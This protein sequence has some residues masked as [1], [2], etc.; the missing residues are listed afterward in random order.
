MIVNFVDSFCWR[1]AFVFSSTH[2]VKGYPRITEFAKNC[3]IM[4]NKHLTHTWG[5]VKGH[6]H[7]PAPVAFIEWKLGPSLAEIWPEIPRLGPWLKSEWGG[8]NWEGALV[9]FWIGP[10]FRIDHWNHFQFNYRFQIDF[11]T[12]FIKWHERQLMCKYR[13]QNLQTFFSNSQ[14]HPW[15]QCKSEEKIFQGCGV[16]VLGQND[17]KIFWG[18]TP[19]PPCK[20]TIPCRIPLT[21]GV[22]PPASLA[23]RTFQTF[24]PI[25]ILSPEVTCQIILQ[26]C[27][28]IC[29]ET[30]VV[31]KGLK[32][33]KGQNWWFQSIRKAVPNGIWVVILSHGASRTKDMAKTKNRKE[34]ILKN[35]TSIPKFIHTIADVG[36][37]SSNRGSTKH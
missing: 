2:L 11:Q 3:N 5:K 22:H 35:A 27:H 24:L 13:G 20:E 1:V 9:V 18:T 10:K 21:F 17:P 6:F 26:I 23:L 36:T 8:G 37:K 7:L 30:V 29:N 33:L 12:K 19:K 4:F 15:D 31:G 28:N 16:W 14:D 34:S 25:P 32:G